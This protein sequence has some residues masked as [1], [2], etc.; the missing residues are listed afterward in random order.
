MTD[1][2]IEVRATE[3]PGMRV[4]FQGPISPD[5]VGMAFEMVADSTIHPDDLNKSLDM[6]FDAR[7][8][9]AA[10]EELPI[11]KQSLHANTLLLKTAELDR[12]RHKAQMTGRVE[13]IAPRR[14]D[15]VEPNPQDVNAL[16]QHDQRILQIAGQIEGARARIP[17][18]EAIIE[19][20]EPPELFPEAANDTAMAAE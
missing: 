16:S 3:I 19:G 13:K 15:Q 7:R 4:T 2:A 9:L 12:A 1:K 5:G 20:R 6:M 10:R 11:V 8:R 17:Y 14:R 18:L